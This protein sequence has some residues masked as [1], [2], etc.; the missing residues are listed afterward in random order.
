MWWAKTQGRQT[1][2]R[3]AKIEA[4]GFKPVHKLDALNG[5]TFYSETQYYEAAKKVLTPEEFDQLYEIIGYGLHEPLEDTPN[6]AVAYL[7]AAELGQQLVVLPRAQVVAVR[8]RAYPGPNFDHGS[9]D[10]AF[11]EF[12]A[13][14]PAYY[15]P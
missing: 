13:M 15:Y 11:D 14:V 12:R 10:H 9:D 2:E 5:K 6:P 8:L 7:S 4:A 1:P 3:L